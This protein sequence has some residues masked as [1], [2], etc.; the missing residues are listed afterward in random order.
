MTVSFYCQFTQEMLLI[1]GILNNNYTIY[2]SFIEIGNRLFFPPQDEN[3]L[4][5]H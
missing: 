4:Y 1:L 2:V 3:Y 5:E